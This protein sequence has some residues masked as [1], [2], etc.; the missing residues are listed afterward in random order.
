MNILNWLFEKLHPEVGTNWLCMKYTC[1][2][3][4]R[5]ERYNREY[6]KKPPYPVRKFEVAGAGGIISG[7][8]LS[9]N[10]TSLTGQTC[11]FGF[12]VSW[13]DSGFYCGVVLGL[14]EAKRMAE[15]ILEKCNEQ[16]KTER[17]LVE[18]RYKQLNFPMTNYKST[19]LAP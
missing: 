12:N 14:D 11:G 18:E 19:Q 10:P 9:E 5:R 1:W 7:I 13:N 2:I 17:E 4:S 8:V 6:L 3:M 15:F 16:T